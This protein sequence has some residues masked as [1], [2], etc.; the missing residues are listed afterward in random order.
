MAVKRFPNIS[1]KDR[2]NQSE[3]MSD[4]A[5]FIETPNEKPAMPTN[6]TPQ[7]PIIKVEKEVEKAGPGRPKTIKK[8]ERPKPMNVYFDMGTHKELGMI[9]LEHNFEMKD[10][11]YIAIRKF[12]EEYSVNGRLN[13]QGIAYLQEKI[14]E[15]NG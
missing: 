12:L 7:P 6:E 15:I 8:L 3:N 1:A 2:F 13:E 4:V 11:A 5:N 14:R 10:V 9:K